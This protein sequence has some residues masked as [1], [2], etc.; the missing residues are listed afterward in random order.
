MNKPTIIFKVLPLLT[1]ALLILSSGC[2]KKED[3]PV[4]PPDE[5]L[6]NLIKYS[7]LTYCYIKTNSHPDSLIEFTFPMSL[8]TGEKNNELYLGHYDFTVKVQT[9][10]SST[11]NLSEKITISTGI[12]KFINN[13]FELNLDQLIFTGDLVANGDSI[14]GIC[15]YDTVNIVFKT[16]KE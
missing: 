13:H 3:D 12:T 4:V 8:E 1:L 2:K 11:A 6:T 7:G 16:G 5:N 15:R 9:G 10:P 14:N